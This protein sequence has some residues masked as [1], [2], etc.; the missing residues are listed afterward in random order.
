MHVYVKYQLFPFHQDIVKNI[1]LQSSGNLISFSGGTDASTLNI[2]PYNIPNNYS[3]PSTTEKLIFTPPNKN[4]I[5]KKSISLLRWSPN[6]IYLAT[7]C[8]TLIIYHSI[9]NENMPYFQEYKNYKDHS[10]ELTALAWSPDSQKIASSSLSHRIVI[11]DLTSPNDSIEKILTLEM[12]VLGLVWDPLDKYLVGLCGDN[13]VMVW[14]TK[15]WEV[16]KAISL[17]F[18]PGKLQ[19]NSKREDRKIDWSPDYKYLLSPSLDDK[20]VPVVCALDRQDFEVKFTFMGP[21]S[22]INCIKFNPLLFEKSGA[23][24]SVFAVGDNDGNISIWSMGDKLVMDKPFFLFKAHSNGTELI[25]DL[26]WNSQGNLLMAT[27]LKRYVSCILFDQEIFGKPLKE[28]EINDFRKGLFGAKTLVLNQGKM[29]I[30][31]GVKEN[32][33]S[34]FMKLSKESTIGNVGGFGGF[35]GDLKK[36]NEN[37]RTVLTE[38]KVIFQNGKKKI[39]P[40]MQKQEKVIEKEV[41]TKEIIKD[42][43]NKNHNEIHPENKV[44][45]DNNNN[46]NKNN[47][48]TKDNNNNSN[49]DKDPK[50]KEKTNKV[51]KENFIEIEDDNPQPNS[52]TTVNNPEK[53]I[54]EG[55]L[56][57]GNAGKS[58]AVN[59]HPPPKKKKTIISKTEKEK[60][61]EKNDNPFTED[62]ETNDK[63]QKTENQK[64][65]KKKELNIKPDVSPRKKALKPKTTDCKTTIFLE[66]PKEKALTPRKD[67][68]FSLSIP[69]TSIPDFFISQLTMDRALEFEKKVNKTTRIRCILTRNGLKE[70]LWTDVLD[71]E[72]MLFEQNLNYLCFYTNKSLLFL[73]Y[74][75]S[76]RR[77]ELPLFLSELILIKINS[78]ND[79]LLFKSSGDLK[80]INL[81]TKEEILMENIAFLLKNHISNYPESKE[82]PI[83]GVFIDKK[84]KPYLSLRPRQL[85]FFNFSMKLWQKIETEEFEIGL[86]ENGDI[87]LK[88]T[89]IC[90]KQCNLEKI[91]H[92]FE[93]LVEK[94]PSENEEKNVISKLE[95]KL[96]FFEMGKDW[97]NYEEILKKYVV[98]LIETKELHKIRQIIADLFINEQKKEF[99][100]VKAFMKEPKKLYQEIMMLLFK[101]KGMEESGNEIQ[102]FIEISGCFH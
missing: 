68:V 101:T 51:F 8:E 32:N 22:S 98:K 93:Q 15:T 28:D 14:R 4:S 95:E 9:N 71:G 53:N 97:K 7:A 38:Q 43:D 60:P 90:N 27:T 55:D 33:L 74:P 11:R 89:T 45:N 58:M 48:I 34:D 3:D 84:S 72:V 13:N 66:K 77:A 20:I 26:A 85:Y 86:L 6:D 18:S 41:N 91:D 47:N 23:I 31:Q 99:K 73:L 78:E 2:L 21:F 1:A 75:E 46:N 92:F 52:F 5:F 81:Q 17:S 63:T 67:C 96:L 40:Q 88:A 65:E 12:K 62:S 100:F 42:N 35:N 56:E 61:I 59:I 94:T 44:E 80:I 70:V 69:K 50:E 30:F 64:L 87:G 76:G 57:G 39:I 24:I 82:N 19:L 79:L 10:L 16:F 49:D 54:K 37:L 36:E 25:E 83:E 29:K 102:Q